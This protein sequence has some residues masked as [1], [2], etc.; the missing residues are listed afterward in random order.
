M[1]AYSLIRK[2]ER[3]A[4][5]VAGAGESDSWRENRTGALMGGFEI[6]RAL[7]GGDVRSQVA[8]VEELFAEH[9]IDATEAAARLKAIAGQS[10]PTGLDR[11]GNVL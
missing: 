5:E 9:E 2:L 7:L 8:E 6:A 11:D 10:A 1:N 3:F 4:T